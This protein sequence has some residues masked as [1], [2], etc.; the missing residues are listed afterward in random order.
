MK[1]PGILRAVRAAR[2]VRAIGDAPSLGR[3]ARK[4]DTALSTRSKRGA[5]SRHQRGNRQRRMVNTTWSVVFV[6]VVVVAIAGALWIWGVDQRNHAAAEAGQQVVAP[7]VAKR[8]VSR[9]VSPT[10]EAAM[11]L[12][13]QS[14]MIREPARVPEFFRIGSA[15]PE[16]VVSF[17]RELEKADRAV[18]GYKWLSSMDANGLLIDGV[19]VSTRDNGKP[20][21]RL[22]LLTPD[23]NGKWKIDFDA[24]ART[25][26]PA[27]SEVMTLTTGPGL[28]RV[29]FV[30][31]SYYNGPFGDES[32]WTCYRLGSTDAA[33]ELL[34]YCR[35]GS[36]QAA[37]MVR[38]LAH[39]KGT[40]QKGRAVN[41]AT[42]EIRRVEG[43]EPRQFEISRVLAEDW[44]MSATPFDE[45]HK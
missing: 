18:T 9:F 1:S 7:V 22:A 4:W 16:A 24:L 25:V 14:L 13:K 20:N 34:G 37:A 41:R 28:V 27:W 40:T 21:T 31:D 43:A 15:S 44:V 38:M 19:A 26:K 23:E 3:L 32:R 8:V 33:T 6:L 17:L 36:A 35:N 45:Q 30:K 2:F 42:L 29:V 5:R 10:R 11:D 12:V 39:V